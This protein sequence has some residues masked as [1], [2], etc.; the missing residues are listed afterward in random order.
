MIKLCECGC[1]KEITNE[2][3]RFINGHSNRGK[4]DVVL[5]RQQTMLNRYGVEHSQ[6]SEISKAKTK[7]TLLKNYGVEHPCQSKEIQEK[8]KQT[9]L[10]HYGVKNPSLSK[11]IQE[12]KR[13]TNLNHWGFESSNQSK[14]IKEKKK[15]TLLKNY[16]VD[17]F[18]KTSEFKQIAR[19]TMIQ[20]IQKQ[21]NL[22]EP[23]TP[24][25]GT[26]ER[27]CLNELQKISKYVI[28]RNPCL[29]GYYPD[30]L[31]EQLKLD[32]EFDEE[33]H[34]Y[35][36]QINHDK[37]RDDFLKNKD[38]KV[39]RISEKNWKENKDTILHQFNIII[40]ELVPISQL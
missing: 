8:C 36:D 7:E 2:K 4:R 39:F 28:L 30:G 26:L 13:K 34:S 18:S 6:Q 32:I 24:C 31:I 25:I 29:F 20:T 1:N 22:N 23:P 19:E 33:H 10:E 12:K 3:N 38:Y 16:G 11:E 14:E 37:E 35:L 27:D 21:Y 15:Q 5:K 17:H 9:C 40:N